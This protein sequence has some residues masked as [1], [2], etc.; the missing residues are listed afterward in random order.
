MTTFVVHG[1][2]SPKGSVVSFVGRKGRVVTKSD[3]RSL[4]SWGRAVGWAA[5]EARVPLA[6]TGEPVSIDV[7]FQFARPK[8]VTRA[9]PTTRPDLDKLLRG[10]FDALSGVAFIDD[11]Q[12]V[13][14]RARKLYGPDART[15]VTV[16]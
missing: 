5:R 3:C 15:T 2:A 11:S 16:K 8:T 10:I 9:C 13:E 6:P 1:A 14:T 12:V 4:A 7:L